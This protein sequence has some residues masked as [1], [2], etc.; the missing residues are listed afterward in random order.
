[1]GGITIEQLEKSLDELQ[2]L[3]KSDEE[4]TDMPKTTKEALG[5]LQEYMDAD[6]PEVLNIESEE[7]NFGKGINYKDKDDEDDDED[8]PSDKDKEEEKMN[9]S[10]KEIA[11][12][13]NQQFFEIDGWLKTLLSSTS[14]SNE[15]IIKSILALGDF[16]AKK[17]QSMEQQINTLAKSIHALGQGLL[18]VMENQE[19]IL[20]QPANPPQAQQYQQPPQPQQ[21]QQQMP[22]QTQDT[23]L[24]NP[25]MASMD[26]QRSMT[27]AGSISPTMQP[28]QYAQPQ[29]VSTAPYGGGNTYHPQQVMKA[30]VDLAASKQIDP[31]EVAIYET[32]VQDTGQGTLT[33]RTQELIH[34]YL[35]NG[36]MI[37]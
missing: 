16:T 18:Q 17:E 24:W 12:S 2:E 30:L 27:G 31:S 25:E 36:G 3:S 29:N 5:G 11:K 37:Q 32:G 6:L 22:V 10:F 26:L 4:Q 7:S 28:P 8:T 21:V 15:G 33:S 34:Q 13:E 1:M 35:N 14:K 20:N 19:A 9:K 23:G